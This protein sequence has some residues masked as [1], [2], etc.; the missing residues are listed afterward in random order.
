MDVEIS[1]SYD[2]FWLN[3][4][5]TYYCTHNGDASTKE[6][7]NFSENHVRIIPYK[8]TV[9]EMVAMGNFELAFD[10]LIVLS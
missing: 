10:R 3:S 7:V 2:V 9:T 1:S 6:H 5:L 4:N 8:P